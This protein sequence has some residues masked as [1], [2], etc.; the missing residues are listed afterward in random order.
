MHVMRKYN[1]KP[2]RICIFL[3]TITIPFTLHLNVLN[4]TCIQRSRYFDAILHFSS[5][6][7]FH[8]LGGAQTLSDCLTW[9]FHPTGPELCYD[10]LQCADFF[11]R[12][13]LFHGR[14]EVFPMSTQQY[15][16]FKNL[17]IVKLL[18]YLII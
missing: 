16:D 17:L 7:G 8:V 9:E 3:M 11:I 2:Q 12:Y 18:Y 10:C 15:F 13:F 14:K 4:L 5:N 6:Q 1:A